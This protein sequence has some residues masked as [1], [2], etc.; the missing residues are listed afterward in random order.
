MTVYIDLVVLLNLAVDLLLLL[1]TNRLCGQ[2]FRFVRSVTAAALG[3]I[4]AGVCVLPGFGFL[5]NG[6]WRIIFLAFMGVIAFGVSMHAFRRLILFVILSFALG[7]MAVGMQ[8]R[9]VLGII[10]GA[11]GMY[12]LCV[13]GFRG[14]ITGQEF[15]EVKLSYRGKETCIT[16]MRDTGN[17]LKDPITGESVLVVGSDVAS[18]ITGLTEKDLLSPI[19]TMEQRKIPNLRLI[20]YRAVGQ[21]NGMLLALKLDEVKIDKKK[22][23]TL[24]AFAPQ[25]IGSLEGYQALTGGVI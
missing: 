1:G 7:G 10:L 20:P 13:I 15:V 18:A 17:T 4:Y 22:A 2:P 8:E 5:G 6:F 16:A 11:S 9:S 24:V 21:P 23:G 3:G 19:T 12:L 14:R 25:Q